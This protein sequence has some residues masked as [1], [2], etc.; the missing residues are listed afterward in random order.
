MTPNESQRTSVGKQKNWAEET[1][2]SQMPL[3]MLKELASASNVAYYARLTSDELVFELN[4]V[5]DQTYEKSGSYRFPINVVEV[6]QKMKTDIENR[7]RMCKERPT[8]KAGAPKKVVETDANKKQDTSSMIVTGRP[9]RWAYLHGKDVV[10]TFSDARLLFSQVDGN[11]GFF[12]YGECPLG[13]PDARSCAVPLVV[14]RV[15]TIIEAHVTPD[16]F[17]MNKNAFSRFVKYDV[18]IAQDSDSLVFSNISDIL[19]NDSNFKKDDNVYIERV[20]LD[21]KPFD[22]QHMDIPDFKYASLRRAGQVYMFELAF[23]LDD[24]PKQY[25]VKESLRYIT[26][27]TTDPKI[28]HIRRLVDLARDSHK[29]LLKKSAEKQF[30]AT[31]D[32]LDDAQFIDGM[33]DVKQRIMINKSTIVDIIGR[34][35]LTEQIKT[36]M[37]ENIDAMQSKSLIDYLIYF[38]NDPNSPWSNTVCKV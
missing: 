3:Y 21:M 14:S 24:D 29:N 26:K 31:A 13:N 35:Q 9:P 2:P 19:D 37:I 5:N 11:Q 8:T 6:L 28:K 12:V 20:E 1:I 7:E 22:E 32:I 23:G 34:S 17:V 25:Q 4:K 38:M 15:S 27:V 30:L 10:V 18:S 36:I 16:N 33:N